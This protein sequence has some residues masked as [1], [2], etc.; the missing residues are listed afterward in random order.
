MDLMKKMARRRKR[1]LMQELHSKIAST[2]VLLAARRS[3]LPILLLP[4]QAMK[5]RR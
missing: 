3:H 1:S 2:R 4:L 5:E